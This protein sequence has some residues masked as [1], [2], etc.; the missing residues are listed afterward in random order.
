MSQAKNPYGDG[1]AC[2]YIVDIIAHLY[3]EQPYEPITT[4]ETTTE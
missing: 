1:H 4:L 3:S 2:S